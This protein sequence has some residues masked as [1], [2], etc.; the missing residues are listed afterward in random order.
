MKKSKSKISKTVPFKNK[1]MSK[2]KMDE[3]L[4]NMGDPKSSR[5][6]KTFNTESVKVVPSKDYKV[7]SK[8]FVSF[9]FVI[10]PKDMLDD[11]K[12]GEASIVMDWCNDILD[13]PDLVG[14]ISRIKKDFSYS[15]I[16]ILN[17]I[18]LGI[19]NYSVEDIKEF[20]K[21]K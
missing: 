10:E 2:K 18:K 14:I 11:R 17:F 13:T 21:L 4:D 6:I 12:T 20:M 9:T 15:D 5:R 16:C 19:V 3:F 7:F 1:V 8:Y